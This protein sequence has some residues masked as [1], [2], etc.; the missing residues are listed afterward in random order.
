[1]KISKTFEFTLAHRFP[2]S[3]I[4]SVKFGTTYESDNLL[5]DANEE[6]VNKFAEDVAK[7]VYKDTV[8]D[9]K[10]AAK[11]N[12]I[13]KSVVDGAKRSSRGD[14]TEDEAAKILEEYDG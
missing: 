8:S 9:L 4:V 1:M 14:D 12:K 10:R 7:R 13:I 5:E 11:K 3:D 6:A 2:N